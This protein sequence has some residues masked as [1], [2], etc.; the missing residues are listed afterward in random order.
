MSDLK[1]RLAKKINANKELT[2]QLGLVSK[3]D[4]CVHRNGRRGDVVRWSV[5]GCVCLDSMREAVNKVNE[6]VFSEA[7]GHQPT[8]EIIVQH[9]HIIKR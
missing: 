6:L 9:S 4:I 8:D 1:E 7:G 2:S 3:H 5:K